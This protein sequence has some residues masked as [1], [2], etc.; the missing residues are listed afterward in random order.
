MKLYGLTG[1]VGM[2]KSTAAGLLLSAGGRVI[3]TDEI[4]RQLVQPQQPAWGEVV[5]KFGKSILLPSGEL[6]RVELAKIVFTD[7]ATRQKLEAILHPRIRERWQKQIE[8]WHQ[9]DCRFAVVV[10]PLLF[11]TQAESSFDKI[12]CVACSANTQRTRL[13][14]RNWTLVQIQQRISA[15]WPIEKKVAQAHHVLWSEGSLS[16]LRQQIE[17][18]LA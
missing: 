4:A 9:E 14:E 5:K 2:G 12:I 18:I 11:E 6:N 3:D 15:Q 8:I 7:S 1:G 13:L 10:I 16:V 17:A